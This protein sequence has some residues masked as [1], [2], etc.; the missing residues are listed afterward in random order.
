M[1]GVR[2]M[3]MELQSV[4]RRRLLLETFQRVSWKK[5]LFRGP[6]YLLFFPYAY[7]LLQNNTL[8]V[9]K[10]KKLSIPCRVCGSSNSTHAGFR[11]AE[12]PY[13]FDERKD[14]INL[15]EKK[16]FF[17]DIIRKFEPFFLKLEWR[18]CNDCGSLFQNYPHTESN[19]DR[20]YSSL[21]SAM[22][23]TASARRIKELPAVYFVERT[24]LKNGKVLDVGAAS[25]VTC[26]Y[27]KTHG[28][29]S[30]GIEPSHERVAASRELFGLGDRMVQGVYN[31]TSFAPSSFDGIVTHHVIEHVLKPSEFID[32]LA[33]HL[34]KGGWLLL[35]CPSLDCNVSATHGMH[36]AAFTL[37]VMQKLI[38]KKGFR[39]V[40]SFVV[41]KKVSEIPESWRISNSPELSE[42]TRF[43]SM[44]GGMSILARKV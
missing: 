18:R 39:V 42:Y 2:L 23:M 34:K 3:D 4:M 7:F 15:Y 31:R 27:F 14:S 16:G 20:Y 22:E 30:W 36:I 9:F 35:Q 1:I 37:D 25:G 40:E 21:I 10:K 5:I 29:E 28:L 12:P 8:R 32:A 38:E 44:L 11:R 13:A 43:G 41:P 6:V 26:N 17:G 33:L 19:L 24:Q